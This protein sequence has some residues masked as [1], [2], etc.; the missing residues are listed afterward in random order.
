MIIIHVLR[1][2]FFT[3]IDIRVLRELQIDQ[4]GVKIKKISG[5]I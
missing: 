3:E 5:T 4:L 2:Y 1:F